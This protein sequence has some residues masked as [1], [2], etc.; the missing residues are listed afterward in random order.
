MATKAKRNVKALRRLRAVFAKVPAHKVH[1]RVINGH[2]KCGTV[3]CLLGWAYTDAKLV[4]LGLDWGSHD[5]MK[6]AA[7]TFGLRL[8]EAKRIF[9]N[10]PA[11]FGSVLITD[12]HAIDKAQVMDRL[13]DAIAGKRIKPYVV[14]S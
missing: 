1:M 6:N 13:D 2:S 11:R 5:I 3:H 12:P 9:L 14:K 7:R 10:D 4:S 8:D